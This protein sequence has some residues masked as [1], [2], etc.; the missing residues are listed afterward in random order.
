V[1]ASGRGVEGREGRVT[2]P[3]EEAINTIEGIDE[4]TSTT[5]EGLST[6]VVF[7]SL[8]R[9]GDACAQDVREKA[10]TLL[11]QLPEGSDSPVV[12]KFDIE[13]TPILSIVVSG[14][15]DLREGTEIAKKQIKEDIETQR[16]GGS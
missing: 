6:V 2:K 8:S 7:F 10:S 5:T 13:S 11:P 16:G 15:R 3:L 1:R 12:A 9:D 4:L 14:N